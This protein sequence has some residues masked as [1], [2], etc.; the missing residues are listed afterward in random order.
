MSITQ[1]K[2][3][4]GLWKP[5]YGIQPTRMQAVSRGHDLHSFT[6]CLSGNLRELH[7]SGDCHRVLG[8]NMK[9]K[10]HKHIFCSLRVDKP[11]MLDDLF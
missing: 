6:R 10:V 1:E 11:F 4:V 3:P 5:L 9:I 7:I 2:E 8:M